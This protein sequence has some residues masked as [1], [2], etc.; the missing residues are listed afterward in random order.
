MVS[1]AS[2]ETLVKCFRCEGED[3]PK[4]DG[5]GF[6]PVKRCEACGERAGS[7]SAG[8]GFPLIEDRSDGRMYH[9]RCLPG[10]EFIDM[11]FSCLERLE[12]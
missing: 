3:C 10:T 4:C 2:P 9:V 12:A 8:T 5:T 6:R 11:H 7:V 1:V